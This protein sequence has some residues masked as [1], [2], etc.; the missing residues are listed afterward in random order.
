MSV[1]FRCL[2]V[3]VRGATGSN[4]RSRLLQFDEYCF[5]QPFYR[6]FLTDGED[7]RLCGLER[8][9]H[10]TSIHCYKEA[11][12]YCAKRSELLDFDDCCYSC[13]LNVT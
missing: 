4:R 12:R 7:L 10:S 2:L 1:P 3:N 6:R 9:V 5:L 13:A 8:S 11:L